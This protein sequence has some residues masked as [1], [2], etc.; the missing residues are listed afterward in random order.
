MRF[1]KIILSCCCVFSGHFSNGSSIHTSEIKRRLINHTMELIDK[2]FK[3]NM[4]PVII[5]SD[6][7]DD[8]VVNGNIDN[9]NPLIV[10]NSDFIG[11]KIKGYH[12]SYPMYI[13][14]FESDEKL[15]KFIFRFTHSTI[16]NVKS[17][18]FILDISERPHDVKASWV[19]KF[20]GRFE[21][22][23]SY[24][25]CYDN[26]KDSTIVYTL[27]PYSQYA[28]RP[29]KQVKLAD[30]NRKTNS[31]L[32][33]LQYP[34]DVKKSHKN[35]YFDKN[36]YLNGHTIKLLDSLNIQ[37]STQQDEQNEIDEY[38]K[39]IKQFKDVKLTSLPDYIKVNTSI[40]V[41]ENDLSSLIIKMGFDNRLFTSQYDAH[42]QMTQLADIN[43]NFNDFVTQYQELHFSIIT[44]K[45]DY[46]TAITEIDVNL[47]FIVNTILVL[48]LIAVLIIMNN[49]YHVSQGIMDV[50]SMS[51]GMGIMSPIERL[52]MRIVYF[53]G[54][55]FIFV[56]MPEFQGQI[57]AILSKPAR[58]N[59]E[60]LQDLFNNKYHVF[61][62]G[63]LEKDMINENLWVTKKDQKYLH[64]SNDLDLKNCVKEA[65]RNST[66]AC[67]NSIDWQ[68]YYVLELKNLHLS[69]ESIFKKY[70]VFWT[71][72]NWALKDKIDKARS[73]PVE[74]GLIN[75]F[76]EERIKKDRKIIK[77][78]EKIKEAENYERVDFENLVF[79]FILFAAIL[80]WSLVIFGIELLVHRNYLKYLRE[81][82]ERRKFIERLRARP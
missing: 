2:S 39:L 60:T 26:D 17:P 41:I 59:V 40:H 22:L 9:V 65:Q 72:K 1:I 36:K 13:L 33:S 80:L 64:P 44:K 23:V 48:L 70:F 14:K 20:L 29:W 19:L 57:S 50:V 66:I 27:N 6:L 15:I 82:A 34:K 28:P 61:Y 75:H 73:I 18:I 21:I 79:Y 45:T 8:Q 16:W 35:V 56:V 38:M 31:T 52:S 25:L 11:A 37:N 68:L 49:K 4:N 43:Y 32:L 58:R 76:F 55:L 74:T 46:L 77:K 81:Q 78:M 54:F 47:N 12:P 62:D 24:Y 51:M 3:N 10:V 7:V 63:N 71:K 53:F 67:I 42:N 30:S 5:T 69:K